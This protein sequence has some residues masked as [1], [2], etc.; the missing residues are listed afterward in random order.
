M[1]RPRHLRLKAALALLLL[2]VL[3]FPYGWGPAV[4][5][6]IARSHLD[7]DEPG[8]SSLRVESVTPFRLRASGLR[9]GALPGTPSCERIEVRYSPASL[10]AG[11]IHSAR[12]SGLSVDSAALLPHQ[13]DGGGPFEDDAV[14]A[15]FT[16]DWNEGYRGV[17]SGSALGGP[18]GGLVRI[19]PDLQSGGAELEW[20]PAMRGLELPSLRADASFQTSP[21]PT[22]GPTDAAFRASACLQDTPWRIDARGGVTNG[23]LG[24]VVDLPRTTFSDHDPVLGPLLAGKTSEALGLRFS[25]AISGVVEIAHAPDDALPVWNAF[26]RVS[27]V[28]LEAQAGGTPLRLEG[29]GAVLP[30]S[31]LGSHCDLHPMG[32]RF[33]RFA[34]DPIELDKGSIWFRADGDSLLLTEA[35]AGFC[36]GHVRLYAL[37]LNFESL[38]AGFTLF[39][40]D[41][42]TERVLGLLPGFEGTA[43][44]TLHGKLPL[45]LRKGREVRLRTA[46]LY[47]PPGQVGVIR[48]KDTSPVIDRLRVAALPEQTYRDLDLAL[49][50]LEYDVLRIDYTTG[51]GGETLG[52]RL[53]GSAANNGKPTPVD[54]R[55]DVEG[56]LQ[57]SLNIALRAA[58]ILNPAR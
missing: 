1:K 45:S 39:L 58:G 55:L 2:A 49:R 51:E 6:C 57:E 15:D 53:K 30:A 42:E 36:G 27:D 12:L 34:W 40:D 29:G 17:L 4:A 50:N 20:T 23:S 38:N 28:A 25:G 41:L 32:L 52:I 7:L 31:G 9:V 54:L 37:H 13:P 43:T 24:A 56:D 26:V 35:S 47:S 21:S 18:L 14:R 19:A 10:L 48:L 3:L 16:L 44:G 22:N 8:S 46:F 33:S 5:G 11:R